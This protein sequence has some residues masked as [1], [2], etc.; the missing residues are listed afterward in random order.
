MYR[1][2]Y[3]RWHLWTYVFLMN[4]YKKAT[5]LA[6]PFS[7][8][9]TRN[10]PVCTEWLISVWKHS[11]Y[12]WQRR[13]R[14]VLNNYEWHTSRLKEILMAEWGYAG[15]CYETG[16]NYVQSCT[17]IV[18]TSVCYVYTM[19]KHVYT[20]QNSYILVHTMLRPGIKTYIHVYTYILVYILV[21]IVFK[22]C[23]YQVRTL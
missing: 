16:M 9:Y 2:Y 19:Y 5:T 6:K 12:L 10:I 23:T 11:T 1:V 21:Q 20:K 8:V 17:Y 18:W 7:G 22:P 14:R 3:K 4:C 13:Y 15:S